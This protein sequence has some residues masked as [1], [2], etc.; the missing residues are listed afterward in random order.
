MKFQRT[1]EMAIQG[2]SQLWNPSYPL[3]VEFDIKRDIFASANNSTFTIYNL[4]Q[5]ARRDIYYDRWQIT[6]RF[7]VIMR[8]GYLSSPPL[9]IIFNGDMRFA[10]SE[11]RR[12]D[13]I[14]QV[15]AFDG[16]FAFYQANASVTLPSGYSMR[17]AAE[18]LVATMAPYG[19]TLGKVSDIELPNSRGI[20]FPGKT[21]DEL[22]KL[23]PG[24]GQLFVDNGVLNILNANDYIPT[25]TIPIISAASGLL[26]TPRRSLGLTHVRMVFDPQYVVGQL[27]NLQCAETWLNNPQLKVVAIH[28]YGKMSGTM[29]GD[30]FTELDLFS[31]YDN[32][33]LTATGTVSEAALP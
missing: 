18:A 3:T 28:H 8:A 11:R 20:S 2:N 17:S 29:S 10:W 4:N 16:G 22:Q 23:V 32:S 13:W 26:G 31:G 12:N 25:P 7:S 24:D 15:E 33:G 21:W 14:T 27:A 19:V 1:Y 5:G 30:C 9:P 6:Q